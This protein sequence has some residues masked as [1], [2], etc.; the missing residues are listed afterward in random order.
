MENRYKYYAFIS[1][2]HKDKTWA[3]W[4]QHEMEYYKLPSVLNGREDLPKSFR[5]VFRDE[6]ELAGGELSPQ[7]SEALAASEYLIVICS[8]NS[9]SSDYVNNEIL[10]FISIGK[11]RNSDYRRRIFPF[12][13]E[14]KPHQEKETNAEE[15]FPKSIRGF[16][17][18]PKEPIELIAGNVNATGRNQAFMKILAG[19]LHDKNVR[20]SELWDRYENDKLEEEARKK[21]EYDKM[22]RI[23]ARFISEKATQLVMSGDSYLARKLLLEFLPRDFQDTD[24]PIVVDVERALRGAVLDT[25][26]FRD[27]ERNVNSAEFSPDETG[28]YIVSSSRDS[29][30]RIW[31]SMSGECIHVLRGHEGFVNQASF[32]PDGKTIASVSNDK[33][34]RIWDAQSGQCIRTLNGHARAVKSILFSLD[35]KYAISSSDDATIRVWEVTTGIC[36]HVIKGESN[37]LTISS[38]IS[39]NGDKLLSYQNGHLHIWDIESGRCLHTIIGHTINSASF[40]PDGKMIVLAPEEGNIIFVDTATRN[41]IHELVG[42]TSPAREVIFSP[43]GKYIVIVSKDKNIRLWD[44][45]TCRCIRQFEGYEGTVSQLKF[46]PDG[47]F[48]AAVL[49]GK[50]IIV[51]RIESSQPLAV[52]YGH[53]GNDAMGSLSS[54]DFSQDGKHLVSASWFDCTI[55]LWDLA[56]MKGVR[57]ILEKTEQFVPIPTN[58]K[59]LIVSYT[60]DNTIHIWKQIPGHCI[61]SIETYGPNVSKISISND[62]RY[63]AYASDDCAIRLCEVDTGQCVSTLLGHNDVVTSLLFSPDGKK[64]I[65]ASSDKTLRIWDIKTGRCLHIME[66]HKGKIRSVSI[67][68]NGKYIV[69]TSYDF[70]NTLCVWDI[71]QG[72]CIHELMKGFGSTTCAIFSLDD[73]HIFSS[74]D[75]NI[76]MWDANSGQ[77][78]HSFEGH[79][80]DVDKLLISPDGKYLASSGRD[81][82]IRIWDIKSK[83]CIQILAHRNYINSLSLS[84]DGSYLLSISENTVNIWNLEFGKV[85]QSFSNQKY[86]VFSRDGK[87]IITSSGN[88]MVLWDFPSLE[89]LTV[90]YRQRYAKNPLSQSQKKELYLE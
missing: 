67:S 25:T 60:E 22:F 41:I 80:N 87:H 16:S 52:F 74:H 63:L 45:E 50:N 10:E 15:C 32:S 20:F 35:G 89:E 69:S 23:N 48:F 17:K 18:D 57:A 26:V 3:K 53:N 29:T 6:D 5:P 71:E 70:Y 33:S 36:K 78:I 56:P 66:G 34:V 55:R 40:S 90:A 72:C 84:Q 30:I 42:Q 82:R 73:K 86:S 83:E 38:R 59:G 7:I 51:W 14:G 21:E 31:D 81:G 27:H 85:V 11:T 37:Y 46:S 88:D 54:L 19:T 75:N 12:I 76:N 68:P 62:G 49:N 61:Q 24:Q 28:K 77:L 58:D 43:N 2:N 79:T 9:A 1:Y 13:V 4:V 65:S 39:P 47:R 8:P 64:I 44:I